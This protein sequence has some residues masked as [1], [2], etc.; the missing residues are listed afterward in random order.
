MKVLVD[1]F[2]VLAVE[3][4]MLSDL[5]NILS[6]DIIMK[7]DDDLVITIAAE[8]ETS[9]L[10]RKRI[11]EKLKTLQE[12]LVILNRFSHLRSAGMPN[13]SSSVRSLLKWP[14][15]CRTRKYGKL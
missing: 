8:S 3:K 5:A 13:H 10:E 9:V 12:G 15:E 7:L 1:N 11:T 14:R 6:P 2:S 4:C